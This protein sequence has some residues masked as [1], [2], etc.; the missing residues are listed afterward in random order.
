MK[1]T[2]LVGFIA[3][4]QNP[5]SS[6]ET[7]L[8]FTFRLLLEKAHSSRSKYCSFTGEEPKKKARKA[9][10]SR[11]LPSQPLTTEALGEW[12]AKLLSLPAVG[13]DERSFRFNL[14]LNRT[15]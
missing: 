6:K 15:I 5:E 12:K 8:P 1:L 13:E 7:C 10:S 3:A 2:T 4:V 14:T 11:N 9:Y